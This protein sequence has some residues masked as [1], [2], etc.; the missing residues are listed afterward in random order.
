MSQRLTGIIISES[1]K[2]FVWCETDVTHQAVFIH[3]SNVEGRRILHK[4]D[5][6]S[7]E[8]GLNPKRPGQTQGLNVKYLG[9][10]I[11]RQVSDAVAQAASPDPVGF[12][13]EDGGY[14]A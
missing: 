4:L 2:G 1:D 10:V 5:R 13:D 7:F 6:V 12:F 3:L 11:A 9:H 14:H 8:L